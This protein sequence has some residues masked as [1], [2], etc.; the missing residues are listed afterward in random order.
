MA[1]A[2]FVVCIRIR[3]VAMAGAGGQTGHAVVAADRPEVVV[4]HKGGHEHHH[5]RQEYGQ[6]GNLSKHTP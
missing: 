4:G 1:F 6:C 2:L 5:H 3:V